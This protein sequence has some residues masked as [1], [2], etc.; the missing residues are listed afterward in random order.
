MMVAVDAPLATGPHEENRNP[1]PLMTTVLHEFEQKLAGEF[2]RR[3]GLDYKATIAEAI[4]VAEPEPG[5][6]VLDVAT[7]SGIIAR[8]LISHVGEK[9]QIIC[10]DATP[11][12]VERARLAAQ[13]AGQGRRLEWQVAPA[14]KL[15]FEAGKFDL[16]T[17]TMA[18]PKLQA[19]QFLSEAHRVLKTGGRLLLA[20]ELAPKTSFGDFQLK[21]RRNWFQFIARK[22]AEAS[23]R[24]YSS[25][26]IS[27]L[28]NAAG[29]RQSIIRVLPPKSRHATIF[30]LIKAVK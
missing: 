25:E 13:S 22:P 9:G 29:F 16:I 18:F 20:T 21:L 24:F 8:Q 11:E 30:S 6:K 23:A 10:I 1:S 17:C 2:E 14:E 4:A 5:M 28:L 26:E 15:P 7:G 12:L 19:Q 3:T 27:A